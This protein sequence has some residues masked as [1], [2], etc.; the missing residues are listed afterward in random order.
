[1]PISAELKDI[2]NLKLAHFFD[3]PI[4]AHDIARWAYETVTWSVS[5]PSSSEVEAFLSSSAHDLTDAEIQLFRESSQFGLPELTKD[6]TG[7]LVL[8][9]ETFVIGSIRHGS[10][11]FAR[12]T[13]KRLVAGWFNWFGT[14]FKEAYDGTL[15][16]VVF[17]GGFFSSDFHARRENE[18]LTMEPFLFA[19]SRWPEVMADCLDG[20]SSNLPNTGPKSGL[21]AVRDALADSLGASWLAWTLLMFDANGRKG[22]VERMVY[23]LVDAAE[24]LPDFDQAVPY[25]YAGVPLDM[26]GEAQAAGISP[27]VAS[28][29]VSAS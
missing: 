5:F 11:W 13:G 14:S 27:D 25:V 12:N 10:H 3:T 19:A 20:V 8:P 17:E 2:S 7:S 24:T 22:K 9:A 28:G 23:A 26:I 1:M 4:P 18:D 6:M 16:P 21:S 29:I 15:T